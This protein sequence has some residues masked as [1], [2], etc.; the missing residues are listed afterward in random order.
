M[1]GTTAAMTLDQLLDQGMRQCGLSR[2]ESRMLLAC[3]A[4]R[5]REWLVGHG[6][7]EADETVSQRFLT[8]AH[9]RARGEP[10]AYLAGSR[11]FFS[12]RF[13]V[14]PAVLIPR[15]ETE[16]L[17]EVALQLLEDVAA[18]RLLD[19][20]TGSGVLAVTLALERPDSVVLAT[21]VS[22]AA[23]A[24]AKAN[25]ACLGAGRVDF[26]A[27][28]WWQAIAGQEGGF[29]LIVSNPPYVAADDPHLAQGDLRFEPL[30]ALSA[31][32]LGDEDIRRLVA[33]APDWLGAGGWLALEHGHE[34]GG[35][36]RQ[37]MQ[38]RGLCAI[39]THHDLE[40]R[41]RVTVGRKAVQP[42][43]VERWRAS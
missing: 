26:R 40:Q 3:A 7:E 33:E 20:G 17:V 23:L 15:P 13:A 6:L 39:F 25:A 11:E 8:L 37:L 10:V 43:G 24:V 14:T 18:P 29:D 30:Q 31:G 19:L 9:R 21:D 27:G 34:Q 38:Q 22:I 42:A 16:L 41:E 28:D 5:A 32:P 1:T 12:R 35:R 36:C 2:A 4:G